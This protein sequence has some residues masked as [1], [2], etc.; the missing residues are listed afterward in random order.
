MPLYPTPLSNDELWDM[1]VL[2]QN[3]IEY[4]DFYRGVGEKP[5]LSLPIHSS[6]NSYMDPL[7]G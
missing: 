5:W 7:R 3:S 6:E 1:L 2:H 4:L